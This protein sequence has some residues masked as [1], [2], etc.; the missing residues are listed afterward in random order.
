MKGTM[1]TIA[2][3][4]PVAIEPVDPAVAR[5]VARMLAKMKF[6]IGGGYIEKVPGF[7]SIK[8]DNKT[9]NC[10]ALCDEDGKRKGMPYNEPATMMWHAAL[11]AQG[12]PGL[13]TPHG[14]LADYIV[15]PI[16]ILYGDQ[17][18]M[19]VL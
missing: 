15:G 19:E 3:D 5:D 18:F 16:V 11:L 13:W 14:G 6:G 2:P 9:H 12:H 1:M 10:V 7:D 17:E 8:I 4:S